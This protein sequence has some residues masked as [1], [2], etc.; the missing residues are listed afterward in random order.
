M[1]KER[2]HSHLHGWHEGCGCLFLGGIALLAF[3]AAISTPK[4]DPSTPKARSAAAANTLATMAKECAVYKANG[5]ENP[6]FSISQLQ[7]YKIFPKDRNCNG[8]QNNLITFQSKVT[9]QNPTFSYNVETG[10]KTCSH[11]GPN[12]VLHGCS[13][14]RNGEW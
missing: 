2:N 8:D 1:T 11:N 13:A 12:E 9:K 4:Y 7:G 6:T 5:K 14:R 3:L 10:E